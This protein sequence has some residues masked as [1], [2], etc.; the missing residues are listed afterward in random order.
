[1]QYEVDVTIPKA[2]DDRTRRFLE[3]VQNSANRVIRFDGDAGSIRLTVEVAGQ[4]RDDALVP[5][6]ERW[7]DDRLPLP[8][9]VVRQ[10]SLG[11][12]QNQVVDLQCRTTRR[13][14]PD[15]RVSEPL[16]HNIG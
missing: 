10:V 9:S 14:A 5:L 16:R 3:A 2:L 12:M 4:C 13:G 1:M 11:R 6:P 8:G 15:H 7:R